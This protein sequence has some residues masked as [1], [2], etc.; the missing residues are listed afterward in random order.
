MLMPASSSDGF[1]LRSKSERNRCYAQLS[2]GFFV[3]SVGI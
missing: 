3:G 2:V 1:Y